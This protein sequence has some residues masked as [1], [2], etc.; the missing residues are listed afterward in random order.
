M[1]TNYTAA[2]E[3][4]IT[5]QTVTTVFFDDN[6]KG[7]SIDVRIVCINSKSAEQ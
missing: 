4:I 1:V 3:I 5:E 7:V 6:M 2:M